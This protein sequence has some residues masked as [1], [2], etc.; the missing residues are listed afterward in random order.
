MFCSNRCWGEADNWPELNKYVSVRGKFSL[1]LF[2]RASI[3][4]PSSN[5]ILHSLSCIFGSY[6]VE[7]NCH[8]H[9]WFLK[10]LE[11]KFHS[12]LQ[13]KQVW[14]V[15]LAVHNTNE[16]WKWL[17]CHRHILTFL[18]VYGQNWNFPD[19]I[20]LCQLKC[21]DQGI[22]YPNLLSTG[23]KPVDKGKIPR[24]KKTF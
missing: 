12:A 2:K 6:S 16:N 19:C 3:S 10:V 8:A 23:E 14:L 1:I 5:S 21:S 22:L 7:L 9:W 13:V 20:Q 15:L 17:L 11:E 4:F 18:V 24:A